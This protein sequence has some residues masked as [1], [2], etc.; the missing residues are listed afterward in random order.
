MVAIEQGASADRRFALID[1]G[2]NSVRLVVFDRS[3]RAPLMLFNEKVFCGLGAQLETTGRLDPE[4]VDLA[5]PNLR[6]FSR[7]AREM[8][9]SSIDFIATAAVRD[10]SDGGEF[11]DKVEEVTGEK[12]T[13]LS[14]KEE[15]MHAGAGVISG[16][17]DADGLMGD[18]GGGSLELVEISTGKTGRGITLPLGTLRLSEYSGGDKRLV[19][20]R[21]K[22]A[23]KK[24]E[25]LLE[26]AD[27]TFYPVGG[28]WRNMAKI[29]MALQ[30]Y[31]LQVIQQYEVE[32]AEIRKLSASLAKRH[33][34]SL[35][36]L[37]SISSR[38]IAALPY[39][40]ILMEEIFRLCKPKSAVFSAHG[41][42]EG[43]FY[44][45]QPKVSQD[46]DPLVASAEEIGQRRARFG[47]VGEALFKWTEGLFEKEDGAQR[48]LRLVA[49]WI[50]DVAWREH[51]DYR[52][53]QVFSWVIQHPFDAVDHPSRVFLAYTLYC[54]YR[55][56]PI[57]LENREILRLLSAGERLRARILGE[58]LKLA[59]RVSGATEGLLSR[60][61]L[62]RR[63]ATFS[64]EFPGDPSL[65]DGK[66]VKTIVGRLNKF[67]QESQDLTE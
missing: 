61:Q 13:L 46:T 4:G 30:R 42:R 20:A 66:A 16:I 10:A 33:P 28:T 31:P 45:Q 3:R 24:V 34:K 56:N 50:S 49:C 44:S 1:I 59:Y 9:V 21:V 58:A 55:G 60:S 39:G 5:L 48:R 35:K 54:R 12:I 63:D 32:A 23:L 43:Y 14:G 64:V 7:L 37:Q 18:L 65:S 29:F 67:L 47:Q 22:E 25:R 19:R 15:A 36:L 6:R 53:Q 51:T 52:A 17:P 40:S 57:D 41:L 8:G 2:S 38:R 62:V 11:I 26:I 27:K